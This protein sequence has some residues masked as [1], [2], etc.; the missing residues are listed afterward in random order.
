MLAGS[1]LAL[2][3]WA[4]CERMPSSQTP[5][6][7][8]DRAEFDNVIRQHKGHVVLVDFWATWCDPC[9]RLFPQTVSLAERYS[10]RGLSVVTLSVDSA[11]AEP[12][13]RDFL[14]S[15]HA[16]G[17]NFMVR[18]GGGAQAVQD[19][20]IGSGAIPYLKLYDR[21]GRLREQLEGPDPAEVDRAVQR[22]LD[23]T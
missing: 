7:T 3:V 12:D 18:D 1:L 10:G 17:E 14:A 22:L 21:Q 6:R 23:E 9:R 4:G 16:T 19:F 15:Q 20:E 11:S 8:I 13:V 2:A 5:V